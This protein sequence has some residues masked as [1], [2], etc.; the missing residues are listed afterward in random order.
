[1]IGF[2]TS[3]ISWMS[4][5]SRP[6]WLARPTMSVR[7]AV[8]TVRVISSPPPSC[9]IAYETRLMRSSPNRICGFITPA[10]AR[11]EPSPRSARWPAIVVEPTSMATP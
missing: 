7:S 8:R 2:P 3:A 10:E 4:T 1:M 11:T 5:G 9:I 6:A